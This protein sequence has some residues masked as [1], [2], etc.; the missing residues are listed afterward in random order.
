[1]VKTFKYEELNKKNITDFL[2]Y[3]PPSIWPKEPMNID[4]EKYIINLN[5]VKSIYNYL[6]E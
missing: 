5:E 2:N 3:Q 4:Y 6:M 1:V